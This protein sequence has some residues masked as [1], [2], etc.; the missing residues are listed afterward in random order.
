MRNISRS[1]I[2]ESNTRWQS[3]QVAAIQTLHV[4]GKTESREEDSPTRLI[5]WLLSRYM[6][7]SPL[8]L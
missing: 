6:L 5:L 8:H 1:V 2:P 3:A 7:C 4:E